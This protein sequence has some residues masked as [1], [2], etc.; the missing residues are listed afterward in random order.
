MKV[1]RLIHKDY[2][3]EVVFGLPFPYN[4]FD[5]EKKIN[6]LFS[7]F[8]P[9]TQCIPYYENCKF[10]FMSLDAL[11]I[12]LY[13]LGNLTKQ[14]TIDI[15]NNF[16]IESF[17]LNQWSNGLSKFLCTYFDDEINNEYPIE[18]LTLNDLLSYTINIIRQDPVSEEDIRL[19]RTQYYQNIKTYYNN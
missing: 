9:W 19:T 8:K 17:Y 5:G 16:Y 10:A 18:K 15:Y 7:N 6:Q 13:S 2:N 12:F 14:E 3:G 11:I 4:Q 1:Y